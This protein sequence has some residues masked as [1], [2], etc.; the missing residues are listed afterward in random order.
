MAFC[1]RDQIVFMIYGITNTI[2]FFSF[3]HVLHAEPRTLRLNML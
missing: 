2:S 3:E 1:I